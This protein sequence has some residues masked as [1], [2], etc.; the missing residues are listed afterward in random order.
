MRALLLLICGV[1]AVCPLAGQNATIQGRVMDGEEPCVDCA[2]RLQNKQGQTVNG[3]LT[4]DNGYYQ[5]TGLSTGDYKVL[6]T[7]GEIEDSVTARVVIVST[8]ETRVV[9]NLELKFIDHCPGEIM[10]PTYITTTSTVY[11]YDQ[12]RRCPTR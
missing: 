3:Q 12:I 1:L 8:T 5:F 9:P 7:G 11:H 2:V 4:D 6:A 10:F